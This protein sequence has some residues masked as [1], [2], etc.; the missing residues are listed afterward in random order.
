M[1]VPSLCHLPTATLRRGL[2]AIVARDR[3][4][5]AEMLAYLGEFDERKAFREDGHSSMFTYCVHELRFSEDVAYKRIRAARA[6]RSFPSIYAGVADGRL[7]LSAVVVLAPHLTPANADDLLAAATH[8]TKANVEQIVADRFP[9]PDLPVRIQAIAQQA[10]VAPIDFGAACSSAVHSSCDEQD[11][12]GS[13]TRASQLAPGPVVD[14]PN[15]PVLASQP[16]PPRVR[17]LAPQRYALQVTIDQATRDKLLRAQEL[18][19]HQVRAGDVGEVLDRA[20]DALIQKLERHKFA[21]TDRPREMS[22]QPSANPRHVPAAIRRTV[23]ERDQDRC[24]YVS[25]TGHRCA[26]RSGLEFD[27]IEP[28]ARGGRSNVEN[29]RLR[30]RAHNQFEAERAFGAGFMA[31]KRDRWRQHNSTH[32]APAARADT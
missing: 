12:S 17:P 18:L 27:H 20:L 32:Q 28:I 14:S 26:E 30:C 4:T 25:D 15:P 16:P 11:A 31:Q 22:R 19:A 23:R 10:P 6:A 5:T 7:H 3:E 21:A 13:V 8:Q 24:T 2:S 9:Q 1:K 29:L